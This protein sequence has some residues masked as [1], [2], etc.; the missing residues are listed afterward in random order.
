MFYCVKFKKLYSNII[1]GFISFV[2][3]L[4]IIT[5]TVKALDKPKGVF[6]PI[7]MYHSVLKDESRLNDYVVTPVTLEKD[8][9]YLKEN[10]YTTVFI[11]DLI[12]YVYN[13][14]N[15]V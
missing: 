8:L 5:I 13:R 14:N 11:S 4:G 10:G 6:V 3:I 12:N 2:L 9:I 1:I 7:L 15:F